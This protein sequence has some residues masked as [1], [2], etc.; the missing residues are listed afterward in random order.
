MCDLR[1]IFEKFHRF[2]NTHI[3]D[4]IDVL[5][6]ID[7]FKGL[8]VVTHT[9][10]LIALNI[11]VWEEVHWNIDDP[12]ALALL[13]SSSANVEGEPSFVE[14]SSPRFRGFSEQGTDVI[15]DLRVCSRIAS[16]GSADR[17]LVDDD[18]FVDIV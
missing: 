12:S 18:D 13:A 17:L 2:L 3:K 9:V 11:Y 7:A 14:A 8:M 16:W 1:T 10:T 15:K 4:V 6:F 5:S